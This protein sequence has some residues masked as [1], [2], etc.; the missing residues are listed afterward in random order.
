MTCR[1]MNAFHA[2]SQASKRKKK[3]RWMMDLLD[4]FGV[5][6]DTAAASDAEEDSEA[7]Y[8]YGFDNELGNA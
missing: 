3:T 1:F 2:I 6:T 7:E 5:A 4:G 8:F